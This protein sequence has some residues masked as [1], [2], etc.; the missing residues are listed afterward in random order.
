[1][2]RS[3]WTGVITFGLA[4][5]PVGLYTATEDHT[6][7]F[8]QL[9]RNTADRIRNRRVNERTGREV[10]SENIVKG[11]ELAEGEY[12]VVEPDELDQIAP[13]RSQ[14]IDITDFVDL[15]AIEPVYFDRTYYVAPRGKEYTK[16]YELLRAAL[17]ESDKAGIATFVMRG[18]Q[19]LTALRAE[20]RLLVMQ[21]LYWADEVRDPGKELPE[22]PSRRAGKGKE[23]TLAIQ[24]V[25]ALSAPWEPGRYHDTY[26]EKVRELVQAKAEGQEIAVAEEAPQATS[27]IDL[28]SVLQGSLDQARG[29]KADAEAR[30]TKKA[31]ARKTARKPAAKAA[32]RPAARTAPPK[33]ARTTSKGRQRSAGKGDLRQL[34]KAELYQ[35]ATEQGIE[36]RSKMSREQLVD[37]LTRA[38][39]RRKKSAA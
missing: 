33:T 15:A 28:T 26:E 4:S 21:T 30:Q 39:R 3:I 32:K 2:A 13:G 20:E 18:K 11:Y 1:M 8:H 22:L 17:A 10:P 23:L 5:L 31:P 36:G 7:H 12:I 35:R 38:G 6:V 27:V 19:Y 25:D 16:V 24:L 9:Q 34:S 29:K 37:A 14:T